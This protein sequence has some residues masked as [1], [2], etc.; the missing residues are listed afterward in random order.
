MD[1]ARDDTNRSHPPLSA[2]VETDVR[3]RAAV[4]GVVLMSSGAIG[5]GLQ[6]MPMTAHLKRSLGK[7]G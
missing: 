7:A 5:V 2:T 1:R 4:H 3:L 6:R